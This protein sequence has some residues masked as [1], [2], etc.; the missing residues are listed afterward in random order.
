MT[1]LFIQ[2]GAILIPTVHI[3]EDTVFTYETVCSI[4][5]G[6]GKFSVTHGLRQ[7]IRDTKSD[8]SCLQ[9]FFTRRNENLRMTFGVGLHTTLL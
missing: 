7:L 3:V 8:V 9:T 5:L 4:L 6:T 1:L 2:T